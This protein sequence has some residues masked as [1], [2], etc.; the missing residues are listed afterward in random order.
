MNDTKSPKISII[1]VC[2][3]AAVSIQDCL[4]SIADQTYTSLE[5]IVIDGSS[6]DGTQSV[7]EQNRHSRLSHFLSEPDKG[8]YDA[9][10]KGL[11]LAK[12]TVVGFLNADDFYS[13]PSVLEKVM[14]S[15]E[16]EKND[17]CFGDLMYVSQSDP[18]RI[19]RHWKSSPYRK[20]KCRSGWMPPHPTFF[21]R[22]KIYDRLGGFDTD[23]KIAADYEIMLRFLEKTG[24]STDY[25]PEVLVKMR[26]G[27]VSN[28][29]LR[30]ILK[31]N[32]EVYEAWK[33][34]DLPISWRTFL[35]KPLSKIYQFF[36]RFLPFR[37]REK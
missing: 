8:I 15:F 4:Q 13:D 37:G 18:T 24:I 20:G 23:F 17:A 1:T 25:I 3:N 6:T 27:G 7:V 34:N 9:M 21:V 5:H 16:N 31:A 33:H 30:N 12:G 10:N 14:R 26:V 36:S 35:L 11:A 19:V 2:R 29:S 28:R 32:Y 22:K